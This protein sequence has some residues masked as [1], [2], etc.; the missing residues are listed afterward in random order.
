MPTKPPQ[1][2]SSLAFRIS[3]LFRISRFEFR[4][5]PAL[6]GHIVRNE[7]NLASQK[8]RN[9][10]NLPVRARHAV[11]QKC[12]TN[13]IPVPL[14]SRRPPHPQLRETN[15]IPAHFEFATLAEGQSRRA[16]EPDLP[17]R[18]HPGGFT[19]SQKIRN[20]PNPRTGA[21]Q[22]RWPKASPDSS[23]NPS[24]RP[25]TAQQ[26]NLCRVP[27]G[28]LD[29]AYPLMNYTGGIIPF[30]IIRVFCRAFGS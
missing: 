20:E 5:S 14:A 7:P 16:G 19:V 4:I 28:F 2:V 25:A 30:G 15:P 10:P 11:P 13:P 22:P 29:H 21:R 1:H 27:S 23:G 18:R 26:D 24:T 17:H 3:G 9:E 6:S 12:K 8:I